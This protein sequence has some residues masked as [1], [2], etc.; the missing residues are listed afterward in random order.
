LWPWA[1]WLAFVSA[2]RGALGRLLRLLAGACG[3]FGAC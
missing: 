3:V 2:R 1:L